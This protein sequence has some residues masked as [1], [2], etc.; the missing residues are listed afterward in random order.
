MICYTDDHGGLSAPLDQDG[1]SFTI[2][3]NALVEFSARRV[4]PTPERPHGISYALVLRPR[5]DGRPWVRFDNAHAVDPK[6]RGYGHRRA[7]YDHWHQTGNDTGSPYT[8]TTAANVIED[9]WREVKRALDE[10]GIQ[11]DL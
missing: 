2:G 6:R 1:S 9:F 3:Q 8:F 5:S 4:D 10:K 11:H 7:E